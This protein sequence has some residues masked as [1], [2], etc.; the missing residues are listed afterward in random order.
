MQTFIQRD[1][2]RGGMIAAVLCGA[3]LMLAQPVPSN[4]IEGGGRRGEP[5][6]RP[7]RAEAQPAQDQRPALRPALQD[8]ARM[9][10]EARERMQQLHRRLHHEL[11]SPEPDRKTIREL[12][13]ELGRVQTQLVLARARMV[14]SAR[15]SLTPEQRDRIRKRGPLFQDQRPPQ[16]GPRA[17]PR[18]RSGN[19]DDRPVF[20]PDPPRPPRP[21]RLEAGARSRDGAQAG[22]P[23]EDGPRGFGSGRPV[24]RN[25]RPEAQPPGFQ[26]RRGAQDGQGM[27]TRRGWEERGS[28][29]REDGPPTPGQFRQDE[30]QRRPG[31]APN[32]PPRPEA[33][34]PQRNGQE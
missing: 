20:Q 4:S 3:A 13:E 1:A 17:F 21:S 28:R 26:A 19:G 6:R 22:L 11:W 14:A 30:L 7:G 9:G 27:R 2:V 32:P 34:A 16:P 33:E 23:R 8:F 15:A 18:W 29:S 31:R 12:A 5:P 25:D 10:R 24:D